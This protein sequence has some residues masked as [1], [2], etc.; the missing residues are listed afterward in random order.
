MTYTRVI[1][2]GTLPDGEVW[3][4]SIAAINGIASNSQTTQ[5]EWN[6][7]AINV[8]QVA[9]PAT[10]RSLWSSAVALT[11]VRLEKRTDQ[12]V[13]LQVAEAALTTPVPGT[14]TPTKPFQMSLVLSLL[15]DSPTRSGRGRM[16]FP[17]LGAIIQATSLRVAQSQCEAYLAGLSEYVAGA[18][19][20][21]GTGSGQMT[22]SSAV[23]STKEAANRLVTRWEVGDLLDV[24]RRRR[25]KAV[26]NRYSAPA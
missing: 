5:S 1:I 6:A 4:T 9:V 26:E 11:G 17:A 8:S 10:V 13:L 21:M 25:D 20:A 18:V 22:P 23:H 7:A 24:Q 19:A 3:S 12:G 2:R 16:Y 15:T 14:G